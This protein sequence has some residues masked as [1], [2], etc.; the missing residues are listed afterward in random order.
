MITAKI[1]KFVFLFFG[2]LMFFIVFFAGFDYYSDQIYI[3]SMGDV[4]ILALC[5][6]LSFI[7][8]SLAVLLEKLIDRFK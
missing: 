2:I 7:G 1:V 5:L 6:L 3:Q 8:Y 4:W